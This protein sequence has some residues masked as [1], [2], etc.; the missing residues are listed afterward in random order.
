MPA[1]PRL[2]P[3]TTAAFASPLEPL[4]GAAAPVW[5]IRGAATE[6]TISDQFRASAGDYHVRY[7]A[8]DH[9]E[10]LF[11]QALDATGAT[12]VR[13]PL[14][15]D[16]GSGSG[17]NSVVPCLRLFP[18]ARIVATDL[19]A[20]LLAILADYL[21]HRDAQEQVT[22]VVMD[23]MGE[24]VSAGEFDLVTGAAILHHLVYPRRGIEAAA[25]ALKPGGTAIFF[26]PFDGYGVLRLAYQ[27]ILAEAK[28]RWARLDPRIDRTL[29]AMVKDIAA[30]TTPDPTRP[31][32]ADLDDKWLFSAEVIEHI[33][34]EVGFSRVEIL[35]HNDHA[36]LYRDTAQV[37]LRLESG[38]DDL[39]FPGWALN[40][41][42][43]FDEAIPLW[44]KRR[45][46][47]EGTVV[48]TKA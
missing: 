10:G 33:A 36:S 44:A 47:L 27:R 6:A 2:A 48:L 17:V 34:R 3:W 28:L 4:S 5:T 9:F 1:P 26:E 45:T 15:L 37:Q 39:V 22:C 11:Q 42:D 41:L 30:R 35:P 23:A 13:A 25:R 21:A 40:I 32:F 43:E 14:V 16:L 18:G 31:G 46:M 7:A 19:S 24:H 12:I 29:R 20:E 8:S 38:V